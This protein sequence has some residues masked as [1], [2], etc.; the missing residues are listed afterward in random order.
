MRRARDE[1][2]TEGRTE[3]EEGGSFKVVLSS[4]SLA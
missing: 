1:G 4:S 3:E 2:M